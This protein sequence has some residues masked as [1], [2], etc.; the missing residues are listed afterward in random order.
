MNMKILTGV[1]VIALACVVVLMAVHPPGTGPDDI[2]PGN[3]TDREVVV[4]SDN[5]F[6]NEVKDI[7]VGSTGH[8]ENFLSRN[9]SGTDIVVM[10]GSWLSAG[11]GEVP[12]KDQID[13]MIDAGIPMIFVNDDTYL[14]QE[15]LL[16]LH[17]AA[18][19]DSSMAYCI[20][21]DS[22]GF[23]HLYVYGGSDLSDVL[24]TA[25]EWADNIS[26]VPASDE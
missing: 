22:G 15:D 8:T 9:V 20:Y 18:S 17:A 25:Y 3:F 14:Y 26:P 5:D 7:L 19:E 12:S 11:V 10:D 4:F 13:G 2:M 6:T 21:R 1:L 16:D 23:T 24:V